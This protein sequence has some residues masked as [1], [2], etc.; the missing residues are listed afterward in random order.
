LPNSW[1]VSNVPGGK[2]WKITGLETGIEI[3]L[4]CVYNTAQSLPRINVDKLS[5]PKNIRIGAEGVCVTGVIDKQL[6]T[7]QHTYDVTKFCRATQTEGEAIDFFCDL[8]MITKPAACMKKLCDKIT[9]DAADSKVCV[10][11][12]MKYQN[13]ANY[14]DGWERVWCARNTLVSKKPEECVGGECLQ[15]IYDVYDFGWAEATQRWKDFYLGLDP[16]LGGNL[17]C[18]Q[19]SELNKTLDECQS[20]ITLQYLDTEGLDENGDNVDCWHDFLSVPEGRTICGGKITLSS[21]SA[22]TEEQNFFDRQ[23]RI[24]QCNNKAVCGEASTDT[25]TPEYGVKGKLKLV[26]YDTTNKAT[27]YWQLVREGKLVCVGGGTNCLT[28]IYGAEFATAKC[29]GCDYCPPV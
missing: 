27:L 4:R 9:E 11:D 6:S 10:A 5:D 7:Y 2:A 17:P 21:I 22:V 8:S 15:C 13:D 14:Q 1:E 20:G 24:K 28:Q 29:S 18:L 3:E 16:T 12:M 23:I 19:V 26:P 25:C